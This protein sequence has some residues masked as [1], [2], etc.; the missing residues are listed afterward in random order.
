MENQ[1]FD[2]N[3]L[4]TFEM[5]NNHQGLLDHGLKIVDAMAEI[6]SEFKLKAAVKLQFRELDTFIHPH[7]K[8]RQDV[9][10]IPRFMSTRLNK[11]ELHTLVKR[12]KQ[13]GMYSMATPFD[14]ASVDLIEQFDI[15]IVKV[16][17]CSAMDWPLL[18]AIAK[19]RRPTI[20]SVG[21]LDLPDI[22]RVVSFF[23]H[24]GVDFALMHCVAIYPTPADQMYLKQIEIFRN[25]YPG[26]VIGFS[27][28][29]SPDETMMIAL[30]YAKGAR[31]F[32]KHVGVETESI[33]LNAYSTNPEQTRAWVA[34]YVKARA[35]C[36]EDLPKRHITPAELGDLSTLARGVFLKAPVK[37]GDV[38]KAE[39]V[40]FAMPLISEESM[41]S[42]E[43]RPG[44]VAD[45]DYD[46]H[47]AIEKKLLDGFVDK[48][49]I[50]YSSVRTVK[51]MLNEAKIKLTHEFTVEISHH[52]GLERFDKVGCFIINCFNREYAKKLIVQLPGQSHPTHYHKIKDETFQVLSGT[53]EFE[54]DG[55][56]RVL[57]PGEVLWMPRG[58][59]HSFKT[60]TGVI[61]E[62]VSTTAL[63][64]SGDSYYT[65]K[66][67]Q[68]IPREQRKTKLLNWGRHQFE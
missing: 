14:E 38:I 53:I 2:F 6:T 12:V 51:A 54:V 10:H 15:D 18:E 3:E 61:F 19:L 24:R 64:N 42:G 17:S 13:Q 44:I 46:A 45:K 55:V 1:K 63:E 22:D 7:F 34:S 66:A 4:F 43:F 26:H 50:I 25:R 11:G 39:H 40:Y 30:A 33:K 56:K 5:A 47:A 23:E 52:Y 20:V 65:E 9:K 31:I 28:H 29:E 58:V 16:A 60:D 35:A 21:G 48:K 8:D 62:E 27:T 67:I 59:W 57:G 41:K 37:K 32:E 36:G 49:E 68:D